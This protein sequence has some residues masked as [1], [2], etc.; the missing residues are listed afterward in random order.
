[1][2][3]LPKC[4]KRM[5][6]VSTADGRYAYRIRQEGLAPLAAEDGHASPTRL[7]RWPFGS[8]QPRRPYS[9]F[10]LRAAIKASMSF[11]MARRS[12]IARNRCPEKASRRT[13][14]VPTIQN[15]CE[16][17]RDLKVAFELLYRNGRLMG[18]AVTFS[19]PKC[20]GQYENAQPMPFRDERGSSL[21]R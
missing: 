11:A 6:V 21:P 12:I 9:A 16:K 1:M 7:Y 20:V 19:Q 17:W 2:H 14:Q 5:K 13:I 4:A 18:W 10:E 15:H 8:D 3:S